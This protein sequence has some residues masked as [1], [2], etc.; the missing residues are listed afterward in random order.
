MRGSVGGG[1]GSERGRE[2]ERL[3]RDSGMSGG[4]QAKGIDKMIASRR[5]V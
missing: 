1:F 2:H 5:V 3:F 4:D